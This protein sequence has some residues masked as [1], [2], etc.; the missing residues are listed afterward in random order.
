MIENNSFNSKDNKIKKGD[1]VIWL[2]TEIKSRE[3]YRVW[4]V[5]EIIDEIAYIS[6]EF[7][8]AEVSLNEL[9]RI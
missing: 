4:V 6:D 9:E 5:D 7:S 8:D 2:D 1:N 3:L